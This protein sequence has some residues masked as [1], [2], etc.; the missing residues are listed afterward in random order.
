M[1]AVEEIFME[2]VKRALQILRSKLYEEEV[3]K[4]NASVA[5]ERRSQIG[6]GDRSERVRTYNYPQNRVT[7]HR[8]NGDDKNFN[9]SSVINGE[10]DPIIDALVTADRAEKLRLQAEA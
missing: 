1:P 8:L 3:A 5:A 4:Q 6:S 10:L 9:L 2:S 7:D